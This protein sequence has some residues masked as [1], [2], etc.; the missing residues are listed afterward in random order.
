VANS[1]SLKD[2]ALLKKLLGLTQSTNDAEALAAMRKAN[3]LLKKGNLNWEMVLQRTVVVQ[4]GSDM[5][6]P[7]VGSTEVSLN[8]K[9]QH[10]FDYLRGVNLGDFR[11][12]VDSL[13]TYF[14]ENKYLTPNQ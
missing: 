5:G 1:I 11:A 9:I 8:D 4:V 3:E 14:K 10:A 12:F 6:D 2:L 13:E 7:V